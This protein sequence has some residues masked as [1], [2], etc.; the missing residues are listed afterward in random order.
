MLAHYILTGTTIVLLVWNNRVFE[1]P[2]Q[3]LIEVGSEFFLLMTSIMM[4]QFLNPQYDSPE[5]QLKMERITLVSFGLLVMLNVSYVVWFVVV[6][7]KNK[8]RKKAWLLR[9]K[10]YEEAK[11][12]K[13]ENLQT[14]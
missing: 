12:I 13:N 10:N 9:K 11:R 1:S 5:M 3:R 4:S 8:K 14:P 6:D 7:F 2:S